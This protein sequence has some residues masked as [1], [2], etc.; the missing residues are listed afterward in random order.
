MRKFVYLNGGG[1]VCGGGDCYG[2]KEEKG[3]G[4]KDEKKTHMGKANRS[5]PEAKPEQPHDVT[6]KALAHPVEKKS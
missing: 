1:G 2:G 4:E 3:A 5:R 6:K